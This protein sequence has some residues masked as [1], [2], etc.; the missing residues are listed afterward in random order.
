MSVPALLTIQPGPRNAWTSETGL[1]FYRWQGRD[2]PS[3][4]TIR[5]MAGLPFNLHQWAITQVV[6]RAIDSNGDLN[7]L[8]TDDDPARMKAAKSWLRAASTEARD[9]AASLG[10]RVHDAAAKGQ[11]VGQVSHDVA[12]FLRQY[13]DWLDSM[14]AKVLATEKQVFNLTVGYAGTFDL[15]VKFPDQT[16]FITDIKTGK[17]TYS[18][19]AL[20]GYAYAMAEFVGEDDVVDLALTKSLVAASGVALLH[21]RPDGWRWQV[22]KLEQETWVAFTGLLDFSGWAHA[23][24]SIDTLLLDEKWGA[25]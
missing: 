24:P 3:V 4:T 11:T 6:D 15:L 10:T 9:I 2:L 1:R 19:H 5:R 13:Y 14:G 16:R 23:H 18:E 8:L 17:G 22:L 7:R 20:Q 12:P 25:A 21:L